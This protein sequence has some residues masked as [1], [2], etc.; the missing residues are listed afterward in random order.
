MTDIPKITESPAAGNPKKQVDTKK[1]TK[2]KSSD[3][4][5]KLRQDQILKQIND[6]YVYFEVEDCESAIAALMCLFDEAPIANYIQ[7]RYGKFSTRASSFKNCLVFTCKM[8]KG[9]K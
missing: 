7:Q 1:K 6:N 3:M 8:L 5:E 9:C 2:S 4:E